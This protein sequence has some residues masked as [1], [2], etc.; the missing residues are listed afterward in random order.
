MVFK[1][2]G[3]RLATFLGLYSLVKKTD[4]FVSNLIA[5]ASSFD[6]DNLVSKKKT[7]LKTLFDWF[8]GTNISNEDDVISYLQ[9][10]DIVFWLKD[11]VEK[12]FRMTETME[13]DYDNAIFYLDNLFAIL[14]RHQ[15][16]L[17]GKEK[18]G[19]DIGPFIDYLST[20]PGY[21][22]EDNVAMVEQS[23]PVDIGFSKPAYANIQN[24]IKTRN[25]RYS[26]KR[27]V[28]GAH[29]KLWYELLTEDD[30]KQ[31][32]G[33][34]GFSLTNY[35]D[36]FV[37]L[38]QLAFDTP[39]AIEVSRFVYTPNSVVLKMAKILERDYVPGHFKMYLFNNY[40]FATDFFMFEEQSFY[41]LMD[42]LGTSNPSFVEKIMKSRGA[43][44]EYTIREALKKYQK[45]GFLLS[46]AFMNGLEVDDAMVVGDCCLLIEAKATKFDLRMFEGGNLNNCKNAIRDATKQL[47]FREDKLQNAPVIC[48]KKI[49]D[50]P[51]KVFPFPLLCAPLIV[52]FDDVFDFADETAPEAIKKDFAINPPVLSLDEFLGIVEKSE[53]FYELYSF[54]LKRNITKAHAQVHNIDEYF[55]FSKYVGED[56]GPYNYG[57][58]IN[59]NLL[60][61]DAFEKGF[62]REL[63]RKKIPEPSHFLCQEVRIF[64]E[65]FL[66]EEPRA[67]FYVSL[68]FDQLI[69]TRSISDLFS[70]FGFLAPSCKR[71]FFVRNAP[72]K[73]DRNEGVYFQ[74]DSL[75]HFKAGFMPFDVE[76]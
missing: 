51:V 12:L 35:F 62:C 70:S 34:L 56:M 68:I 47:V 20:L 75:N 37:E 64:I 31:I 38:V 24:L 10:I 45:S 6:Y 72:E 67:L 9:D 55:Q 4:L 1:T 5:F 28:S 66:I 22:P 23:D 74:F 53:S 49:K 19:A 27:K 2:W 25:K 60:R 30:V 21:N 13:V 73:E 71:I 63:C 32:E 50:K 58:A 59:A 42:Y 46:H 26:A 57:P 33:I 41:L 40:L 7:F 54:I 15:N 3:F 8:K 39:F 14:K 36:F 52:T 11:F 18:E 48:T 65:N 29:F 69:Q 43:F 17:V 61:I 44:L 76:E 16:E